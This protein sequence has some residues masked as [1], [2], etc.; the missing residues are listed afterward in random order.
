MQAIPCKTRCPLGPSRLCRSTEALKRGAGPTVEAASLKQDLVEDGRLLRGGAL[1]G[2]ARE[3]AEAALEGLQGD[4]QPL[5]P[6]ELLRQLHL[7]EALHRPAPVALRAHAVHHAA[8]VGLR[9][10]EHQQQEDPHGRLLRRPRRREH[11]PERRGEVRVRPVVVDDVGAD[12]DVHGGQ[13]QVIG[14]LLTPVPAPASHGV[15]QA[16]G[17]HVVLHVLHDPGL[18]VRGRDGR[19]EAALRQLD[20]QAPSACP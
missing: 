17:L 19:G 11:A 9:R 13:V 1:P 14:R 10:P 16:V 3:R 18:T 15:A 6:E 8:A 2:L 4:G 12:A 20:G 7:Q 5:C